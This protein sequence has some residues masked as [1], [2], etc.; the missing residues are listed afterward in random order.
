MKKRGKTNSKKSGI[1]KIKIQI[2]LTNKWLYTLIAIGILFIIGVGVYALAPSIDTSKG[3]H[4]STQ[5]NV[6]VSGT[7]KT[8]QEAINDG[9]L[10]TE[11][12]EIDNIP[13][14]FADGVDDGAV[15][16]TDPTVTAS[17][18]D[19]VSWSE[20]TGKPALCQSSG[21]GCAA[22]IYYYIA[23][24][25]DGN[26]DPDCWLDDPAGIGWDG[27]PYNY[28]T[29]EWKN[30]CASTSISK[31]SGASAMTGWSDTGGVSSSSSDKSSDR[32]IVYAMEVSRKLQ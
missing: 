21:A 3:S 7:E 4:E 5:V 17:V 27:N 15:P 6:D 14:G 8:L 25:N 2:T 11:W 30:W 9:D 13:A 19:G 23:A 26:R 12:S 28:G 16:E 31:T 1:K 20:V 10:V 22:D 29:N 18:K 24:D 32:L